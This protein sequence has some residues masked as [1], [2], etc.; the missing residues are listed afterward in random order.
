MLSP[1]TD[2]SQDVLARLKGASDFIFDV[3]LT[4]TNRQTDLSPELAGV[5]AN[6]GKRCGIATSRARSE[7]DENIDPCG[8][9]RGE[10]FR[11]P[12][13]LED[14]ACVVYPGAQAPRI[15]ADPR[16]ALAAIKLKEHIESLISPL[17]D[18]KGYA[19]LGTLSDPRVRMAP[20]DYKASFSLWQRSNETPPSYPRVMQLV[21]GEARELDV[22]HHVELLEIGDGTLRCCPPGFNKGA[23]L[24]QLHADGILNLRELVFFGDGRNDV[25]AALAVRE[26]GGVVVATDLHCQDLINLADVRAPRAGFGPAF[27]EQL[28]RGLGRGER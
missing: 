25:P 23:A 7:L 9:K 10:L 12:V 6:C 15:I 17:I 1:Q 21:R 26:A 5:I 11:G 16:A 2:I 4:I 14:G 3:D 22:E 20:Y 24:K 19:N 28:L 18:E 27:V 8:I 13:V